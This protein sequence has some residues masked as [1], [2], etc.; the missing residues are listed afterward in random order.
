MLGESEQENE[1]KNSDENERGYAVMAKFYLK[2]LPL[3]WKWPTEFLSC[4]TLAGT[5]T[6][7]TVSWLSLLADLSD[8]FSCGVSP[9]KNNQ[10]KNALTTFL[11]GDKSEASFFATIKVAEAFAE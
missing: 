7:E 8:R 10:T 4:L 2:K 5:V 1:Q 11:G 9:Q 6:S 3:D